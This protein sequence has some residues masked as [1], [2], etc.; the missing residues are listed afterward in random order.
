MKVLDHLPYFMEEVTTVHHAMYGKNEII[1]I[2]EYN[3]KEKACKKMLQALQEKMET[4]GRIYENKVTH[5]KYIMY[6]MS[7]VYVSYEITTTKKGIIN[8]ID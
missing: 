6:K 1:K 2:G 4:N 5:K 8:G 7:D 3:K